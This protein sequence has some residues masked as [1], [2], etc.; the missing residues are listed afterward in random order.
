LERKFHA[1]N[2][3]AYH[4][5]EKVAVF[6]FGGPRGGGGG[7]GRRIFFFPTLFPQCSLYVHTGFPNNSQGVLK[8]FP[9]DVPNGTLVLSHMVL[10]KFNFLYI[11]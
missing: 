10:P 8:Y 7:G 3:K 2:G 9:Q 1:V 11:N 5:V 6:F 4:A